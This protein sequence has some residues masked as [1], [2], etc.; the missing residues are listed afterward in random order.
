MAVHFHVTQTRKG[1]H[2]NCALTTSRY[3]V[4][5]GSKAIKRVEKANDASRFGW[6]TEILMI[7]AAVAHMRVPE[8]AGVPVTVQMMVQ[9]VERAKKRH[10][11]NIFRIHRGRMVQTLQAK[12]WSEH[13]I[14]DW[15]NGIWFEHETSS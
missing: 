15:T 11:K 12:N 3:S 1:V 5:I 13:G 14:D 2:C 9:V 10:S 6:L 4:Y 8:K 7:L